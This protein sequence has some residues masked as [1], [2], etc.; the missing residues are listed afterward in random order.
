MLIPECVGNVLRVVEFA[1]DVE[2]FASVGV[3]DIPC[4]PIDYILNVDI[5]RLL[6]GVAERL[7]GVGRKIDN[8]V[9]GVA[10]AIEI[11]RGYESYSCHTLT[12]FLIR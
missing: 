11:G 6:D 3:T 9:L 12:S 1:F 5:V 2:L 4:L 8:L 7:H 10:D